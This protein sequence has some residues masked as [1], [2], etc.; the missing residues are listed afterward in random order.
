MSNSCK[1]IDKQANF[2]EVGAEHAGRRL[3]NF[4]LAYL[5]TVP[6]SRVYRIVRR[7][8]VRVNKGRIKPDYRL[9]AG[10]RVRIPPLW[11]EA[12]APKSAPPRSHPAPG[13]TQ[14]VV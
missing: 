13:R 9:Q 1:D 8:E 7:G 2:I 3:D 10:D 11:I 5:K 14:C 6:K 4:L 12:V